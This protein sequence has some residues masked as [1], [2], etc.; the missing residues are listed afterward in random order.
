[1]SE[2]DGNRR[3]N[4]PLRLERATIRNAV[5]ASDSYGL[6]L[7][8]LIFIY[9]LLVIG[10]VSQ[11]YVLARALVIGL[12]VLLA[13]HTSHVRGRWLVFIRVAV[14]VA[15]LI[16]I[17]GT[18]VPGQR[19]TDAVSLVMGI[20]TAASPIAILGRI[21]RHEQV[22]SETILGA[23]CVYFILGLTFALVDSGMAAILGPRHPFFAQDAHPNSSDFLYFSFVTLTTTGY[24]DLT[25][26]GNG[27]RTAAVFEA[28]IGQ[29]FLVTLVARLVALYSPKRSREGRREEP[30]AVESGEGS[31]AR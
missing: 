30:G 1:M 21:L 15:W 9:V 18:L 6:L 28:L 31:A 26:H 25:A 2:A 14:A 22:G 12:T 19:W 3:P 29:I 27:P 23:V 17:I 24:G 4:R 5:R 10:N 8:L 11:E 16:A 7:A 13:F 20:L